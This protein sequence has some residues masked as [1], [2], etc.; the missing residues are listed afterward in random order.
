MNA[1]LELVLQDQKQVL[2]QNPCA[3]CVDWAEEMGF[4]V[5]EAEFDYEI[6]VLGIRVCMPL[7]KEHYLDRLVMDEEENE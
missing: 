3:F 1:E 2:S 4:E 6:I 7:C 5:Q